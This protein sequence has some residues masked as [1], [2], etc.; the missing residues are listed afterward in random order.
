M[1]VDKL[2]N[3]AQDDWQDKFNHVTNAEIILHNKEQEVA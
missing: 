1:T 3:E 2:L